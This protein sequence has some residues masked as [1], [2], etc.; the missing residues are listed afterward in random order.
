MPNVRKF[1]I[2]GGGPMGMSDRQFD[3]YKA[4]LLDNLRDALEEV[5][6]NKDPKKLERL[7]NRLDAE[8]KQP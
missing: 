6:E 5:K 3:S 7:V 1:F 4:Q 2:S 8:L